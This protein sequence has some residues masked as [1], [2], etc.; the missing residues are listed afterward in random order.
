MRRLIPLFVALLFLVAVA[1]ATTWS[2][3][4]GC[5]TASDGLYSL[6]M[7]NN[8]TTT[9]AYYTLPAN[10]T[11]IQYLVI[12]GGGAG[13]SDTTAHDGGGGAGGLLQGNYTTMG[14]EYLKVIVGA[15]GAAVTN[16]QGNNG[17]NSS[18]A[19][20]GTTISQPKFGGG[21][22]KYG[23]SGS[24]GG[25]GG[26]AS[27]GP[28]NGGAGVAGQGYA[29]GSH[30]SGT[31]WGA[32]GGGGA[33]GTG[34]I[35]AGTN[36][37][38]G[39]A[40]GAGLTSYITGEGVCYAGGGSGES[41]ANALGDNGFATCG[42]GIGGYGTNASTSGVDGLA[43]GG[44]G[45]GIIG[46]TS[47]K[48]G[49]GLVI[50]RYEP[51]SD[52]PVASF[53]ASETSGRSPV[54]VTFTDTSAG[55]PIE[56][57]WSYANV[58]G[59]DTT[60]TWFSTLQ[61]PSY[62]FKEGNW[63][64]RLNA[65]NSY[66]SDIT[67]ENAT[68]INVSAA[69]MLTPSFSANPEPSS[70]GLDVTFTG[71]ATDQFGATVTPSSWSWDYGDMLSQT[72]SGTVSHT[73]AAPGTYS[74]N[75]TITNRSGAATYSLQ[76]HSVVNATVNGI[77]DV[78]MKRIFQQTFRF[79][80]TR[81][82]AAIASVSATD[83]NG[84]TNTTSTSGDLMLKEDFGYPYVTFTSSGYQTKVFPLTV[85]SDGSYIIPLEETTSQNVNVIYSAQ[86]YR[87]IFQNLIGTPLGGLSV[88][89]TP[90]NLTMN[91]TWTNLLMGIPSSVDIRNGVISGTTGSDGSLGTPLITPM[92]YR[93]NISGIAQ[94]G[95]S[96]DYSLIEYPPS[97][98]TDIIISM[99]TNVTG[100]IQIIPTAAFISYNIYNQTINATAETLSVNFNDP[101]AITNL[102]IITVTNQSGYVLNQTTYTGTAAANVVNNFTY[103]QGITSP[104]GDALSFG[105]CS[106][107][108]TAGGWN[109]VSESVSFSG[110]SSFTG[111]ATY[112]GWVAIIIIVLVSS[113]FTAST[114]YIGTIGVG[115]MG[116]FF[117]A[118]VKWF[119][120]G[121]QGSIFV[122]MCVFWI[123]IGVIGFIMKKSRSPF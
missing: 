101:T 63:S 29:G 65:T 39:G 90:I 17:V 44:G 80:N 93:I 47:G 21:G 83:S 78:Y 37:V 56:W 122:A 84:I 10:I 6:V 33:G 20:N 79:V 41:H 22:G 42:G 61:N 55:N 119:T 12:S 68:F 107:V 95:D 123:C 46:I 52:V 59:P 2:A 26:G 75:L 115:L 74:V 117:Y 69:D 23:N 36:G 58:T 87:L 66:G 50:I 38:I 8:T 57:N 45:G 70:T 116:L 77:Q 92:G 62:I 98:G 9:T 11:S 88:T 81:T 1:G 4:S 85:D 51:P 31:H 13:G 82:G 110:G 102:T 19:V 108:V 40:G 103:V 49:S 71:T 106:Y 118:T 30:S 5:W 100:F 89:I 25:S 15:G 54:S 104:A 94:S 109:N 67:S 86:L 121:V 76:S 7:W 105:F 34:G 114:V 97:Q 3:A 53:T 99:P 72:G 16:A 28:T 32:A 60:E 96:V 112:D 27:L 14:G 24:A 120:P 113:A 91:A 64:I 48:G 43:G 73:Y 111:N 18:L 35:S